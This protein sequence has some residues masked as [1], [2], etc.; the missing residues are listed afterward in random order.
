MYGTLEIQLGEGRQQLFTLTQRHVTIGRAAHAHLQLPDDEVDERHALLLC[1][2]GRV[3][4]V[5]L[6][7]AGGTFVNGRRLPP[8][9]PTPLPPGAR[10]RLGQTEMTY[11]ASGVEW[12]DRLPAM[13]NEAK[14]R[15][16]W[17][18]LP[19]ALLLAILLLIGR[20]G[21]DEERM[22]LAAK[23]I[24][25]TS[26]AVARPTTT[27]TS[28]PTATPTATPS[29]EPTPIP[30]L[31]PTLPVSTQITLPSGQVMQ[32]IPFLDLP[33]PYDGGNE[34]FGGTA[35]QF[36][37]ASQRVGAGG[38][39][40]SFFDHFYP[41]YPAPQAGL[42]TFGQEP[43]GAPVGGHVLLY[44]G[45]LSRVD[46]YSGHPAF[47]FSTFVRRQPTT[48]VFAAG[49]GVVFDVGI[50]WASGAYYVKIKHTIAGVGD[51][52][53]VYWHLHPD[54]IF[55]AIRGWVGQP[56]PAGTRIGTM[57]N[58]GWSTGHHLHFEVIYDSNQDGYFSADEVVDP[59]GFLP[60]A[61]FPGDPWGAA[62]SFTDA[63]GNLYSH[64]G[65]ASH[66]LWRYPLAVSAA[67]PDAGGGQLIPGDVGGGGYTVCARPGALPPG[68]TITYSWAPDPP[69]TE[70]EAGTGHSCVLSVLDAQLNPVEQFNE[71][72]LVAIPFAPLDL[73]N[74]DPA[75]LAIYWAEPD[76]LLYT[77]LPTTVNLSEGVAT[78]A[79]DRPGKCALLGR[80]RRDLVPPKTVIDV[81]G[82]TSAEGIWYDKVI[83][84]LSAPEAD[85]L[86]F[87]EYSL[88]GGTTWQRYEEPFPL[89]ANGVPQPL[90]VEASESFG[91]GPGRFLV[92]A[93]ATDKTGTVEQPPAYRMV[94]I[95]PRYAPAVP[96]TATPTLTPSPTL[97][98]THTLTPTAPPTGTLATPTP[99]PTPT[100]T[101]TPTPTPT[102]TPSPTPTDTPPPITPVPV[103]VPIP[104]SPL[105]GQE[106]PCG[107]ALVL[108]WTLPE[109]TTADFY[110]WELW[111][112]D[113]PPGYQFYLGGE[114]ERLAAVIPSFDCAKYY[115]WQV[116]AISQGM[117]GEYSE[118]ATY[119]VNL[120]P[121]PLKPAD[122]TFIDCA[123]SL[124]LEWELPGDPRAVLYEWQ[125]E[126]WTDNQYVL[127]KADF[128][129]RPPAV[130]QLECVQSYRWR[131]RIADLDG[132]EG[133]FTGWLAFTILD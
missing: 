18:A 34:N 63:N 111:S 127:F 35:E 124:W 49:D 115:Q 120:T 113:D 98:P 71:P 106:L 23:P 75:T 133:D 125:V 56:I 11:L 52:L 110:K 32:I 21:G 80:P 27:P 97:T 55:E 53:T 24:A 40:N 54:E 131:V 92:L 116:K 82:N 90:P 104:L 14:R 108:E 10:L 44:D 88:D 12:D 64:A 28:T 78:A 93:A 105:N 6:G 30:C 4:V 57:G 87:I 95:D 72:I 22:A 79:T 50:H 20:G 103:P 16:F 89:V 25:Q 85:D 94:V 3:E 19:I 59:Y 101:E 62:H 29:P 38:R 58:T 70:T 66:Y 43:A 46:Y 37:Q 51:Y 7:P 5:D 26:L 129:E 8:N 47:D 33:F 109:G 81:Q 99:T 73:A 17:F 130:V 77:P 69:P 118:W 114:T 42:V 102:A 83:V 31:E 67:I 74:V 65:S 41:L 39:I 123:E 2:P 36:R 9:R 119:S 68:G 48:P 61:D 1:H 121:V 100:V 84:T 128:V 96:L 15:P 91:G 86:D 45:T 76:S 126:L 60:S 13:G 132:R 112:T 122:G 117:D 107:S